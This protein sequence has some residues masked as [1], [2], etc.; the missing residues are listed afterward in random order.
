MDF[1]V[2]VYEAVML[3]DSQ[4]SFDKWRR[5]HPLQMKIDGLLSSQASMQ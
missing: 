5:R 4:H 2:T 3:A 1:T